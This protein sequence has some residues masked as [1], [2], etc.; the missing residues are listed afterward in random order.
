MGSPNI[1]PRLPTNKERIDFDSPNMLVVLRVD[2]C[3]TVKSSLSIIYESGIRTSQNFIGRCLLGTPGDALTFVSMEKNIYCT[4]SKLHRCYISL[5]HQI[6]ER[7]IR[8]QLLVCCVHVWSRVHHVS[9]C[10]P[11]DNAN[12][13]FTKPK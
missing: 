1:L 4:K 5:V 12:K 6:T 13:G 10:R 11:G 9:I 8:V 3:G 7:A 2:Y